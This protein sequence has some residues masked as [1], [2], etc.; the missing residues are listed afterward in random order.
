[1]IVD[2]YWDKVDEDHIIGLVNFA[3]E[4]SMVVSIPVPKCAPGPSCVAPLITNG[5]F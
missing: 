3:L 2:G 4:R 5:S 1:M